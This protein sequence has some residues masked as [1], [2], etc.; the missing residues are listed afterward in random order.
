M[1]QYNKYIY[2]IDI[3]TSTYHIINGKKCIFDGFNY[4]TLNKKEKFNNSVDIDKSVSYMISF[5]V[6]RLDTT[7]GEYNEVLFGRTYEDLDKFL[8]LMDKKIKFD[9]LIYI[10]NFAYEFSFFI[11][12]LKFFQLES[13]KHL[14]IEKN[15]PLYY[16][17][18]NLE[19]R[20]S[21][22]LLGESIKKLGDKLNISK[23]DYNYNALRTPLTTLKKEEIFYNFRD[24]EIMLKSVY[25]LMMN[26]QYINYTCDLPYTKT[27]ISRLNCKK[28]IEINEKIAY[29]TKNGKKVKSNLYYRQIKESNEEKALSE[30][31]LKFWEKLFKG[32]FVYSNPKYCSTV[33]N[34]VL[35][36]DF[37][38]D[39]PFQMLYRSFPR[40]FNEVKKDKL[41]YILE[42]LKNSNEYSLVK[43][44][45]YYYMINCI[46]KLK[47]LKSKF[48]IG[49]ISSNQI[50][51]ECLKNG[52]NALILNGKIYSIKEEFNL[53]LTHID[54]ILLKL[55][56]NFE[57]ID[58]IYLEKADT[59]KESSRYRKNCV[60]FNGQKKSEY[61]VYKELIEK[62]NS[63]KH[64]SKSEIN[65]TFILENVNKKECYS[66]QLKFI[67]ENYLRVKADLNSL[68]GDNAQHLNKPLIEYDFIDLEYKE[69]EKNFNE[70]LEKNQKT[71]YIYGLYV[72]SYARASILYFVYKFIQKKVDTIY[73]D[74]DSLKI[75]K[76]DYNK[77]KRI[78]TSYNDFVKNYMKKY[79]LD[80]GTLEY[81]ETYNKFVT[82]GSKS[83]ITLN[84]ANRIKSTISG[85]PNASDLYTRLL[86][87]YDNSFEK[88]VEECYHFNVIIDCSLTKKLC[89][90]YDFKKEKVNI[91]DYEEELYSGCVLKPV[92]LKM[93]DTSNKSWLFYADMLEKIFNLNFNKK[94]TVIKENK[95]GVIIVC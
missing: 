65:D 24:V 12:N 86:N 67:N 89:A 9:T 33:L 71:S 64:Y 8:F 85:L 34:N 38:S 41:N 39:Y 19:F 18:N 50:E 23:L 88:M 47:N 37:S 20:C 60:L 49:V 77:V 27:G 55:F 13:K 43:K 22:Q 53:Y 4:I 68:Y 28:N 80:F 26:N 3:E 90:I 56:Y 29:Q 7:N 93:R 74:T 87:M 45:P 11:N 76:A 54:L 81:E 75:K 46:L 30:F 62:E 42:V 94:E 25:S 84:S 95:K 66:D 61:K 83:Y 82:L 52:I 2:G 69:E 40:D 15:K 1:K 92:N 48:N 78:I 35:S 59:I 79:K 70:Y 21:Y 31:Q 58:C 14:F 57:I 16:K 72:P 5:C 6:S 73:I 63:F 91:K 32:G 17:I 10:H 36:F 51:C 44:E